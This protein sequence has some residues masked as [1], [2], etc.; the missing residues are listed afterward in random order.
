MTCVQMADEMYDLLDEPVV[1]RSRTFIP[2]SS[3]SFLD[4]IIKPVY[5]IVAAVRF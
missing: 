1:K 5:D 4:K 2:G 3:H